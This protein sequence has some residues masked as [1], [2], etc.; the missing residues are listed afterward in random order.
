M[1]KKTPEQ[2]QRYL[3]QLP[4][5]QEKQGETLRSAAEAIRKGTAHC[6][7][8]AFVAA[9]MLEQCGFPPLVLSFESIDKLEHVIFVFRRNGRWGSVARSRDE[10]LH[11]REPVFRSLRD[12][13]WSYYHPYIDHTG[14][15]TAYQ[16]AHLDDSGADWRTSKKNCWKAE[17]YLIRLPHRPLKSSD[18]RY[19]KLYA[20]FKKYGHPQPYPYWW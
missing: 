1:R 14:R 6:F 4:Y 12:L 10:G 11:G 3:R 7:E 20:D 19:R 13:A 8:A 5:N 17:N 2:V 15:I 9:A 18:R 16:L